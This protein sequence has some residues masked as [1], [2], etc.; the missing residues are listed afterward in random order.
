[1][2][3]GQMQG[4]PPEVGTNEQDVIREQDKI[5]LVL[6]YLFL[7]SLIP[8]LTVKDSDYVKWHAKQGL[9]LALGLI[10]WGIAGFVLSNIP[11]IGLFLSLGFC[12]GYLGYLALIIVG[13]VK[14]LKPARWEIPIV[15]TI[16]AKF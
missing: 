9:V 12:A 10:V 7:L 4:S 11:V 15:S 16:A 8:L 5:M 3:D 1:M 2:N 13:I 14:A 6:A